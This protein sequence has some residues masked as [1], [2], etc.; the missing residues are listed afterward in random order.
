MLRLHHRKSLIAT[1]AA[2]ALWG[3]WSTV[4]SQP[5]AAAPAASS[6]VTRDHD[7]LWTL[8]QAHAAGS[9]YSRQQWMLAVLRRNPDAFLL[10]NIHRLRSQ[11]AL[12]LPT[13][14]EVAAESL[15]AAEALLTR[16]AEALDSTQMLP[17]PPA[18]ART[19]IVAPP[20][21][22]APAPA[23]E[24]SPPPA[25]AA[26][27]AAVPPSAPATPAREP[28]AT[29]SGASVATAPAT[30]RSEVTGAGSAAT[31][32]LT[33]WVPHSMAVILALTALGLVWRA[34]RGGT[35]LGQTVSTLF[36]DTIQL[37]QRAK[38]KVVTVSTAG[39]DMAR[40]VE[41]LGG[42]DQ[43]VASG[44]VTHADIDVTAAPREPALKLAL[45][46]AQLE[47]G[48][49][50]AAI[51]M[52]RAVLREGAAAERSAAEQMLARLGVV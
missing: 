18:L 34:R 38:P 47:I 32:S 9:R 25:V 5:A 10:G 33:R 4:R 52:L 51:A 40:S 30:A 19:P 50:D 11:V 6:V 44:R 23:P 43:L 16:H 1:A 48:R 7:N 49:T 17:P 12:R 46:R 45:A 8:G 42:T 29:A 15:A 36:Q 35:P 2:L 27:P 13:E 24:A 14:D 26:A 20:A 21:A 37:I 22:A 41:R 3:S 39:A 31:G 28:V